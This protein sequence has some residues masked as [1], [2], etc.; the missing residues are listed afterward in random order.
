VD[1]SYVT[2]DNSFFSIINSMELCL[3]KASSHLAIQEYFCLLRDW[4]SH[5]FLRIYISPQHPHTCLIFYKSYVYMYWRQN[6]WTAYILY[7]RILLGSDGR[8]VALLLKTGGPRLYSRWNGK[9]SSGLFLFPH[10][11][12]LISPHRNV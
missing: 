2:E 7:F 12:G 8:M 1:S 10:S 4:K 5:S 9:I 3:R 6:F 11:L